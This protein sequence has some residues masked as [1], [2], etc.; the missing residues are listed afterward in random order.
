MPAVEACP[1]F[2]RG[3]IK[4]PT[5]LIPPE[6][7]LLLTMRKCKTLLDHGFTSAYSAATSKL[8][9]DIVIRNEITRPL[10]GPAHARRQ[11]EI[12]VTG[13][14]GDERQQPCITRASA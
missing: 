6:E 9:L 7:H 5:R 4:D 14:L 12:T 1:H 11:P 8:R 2:L 10:P 3:A 13:G